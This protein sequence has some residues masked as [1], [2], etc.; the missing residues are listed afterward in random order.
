MMA[1]IAGGASSMALLALLLS[2][3]LASFPW[4]GDVPDNL[5]TPMIASVVEAAEQLPNGHWVYR[6]RD[7]QT[8]EIDY[9]ET[10]S[11]GGGPG[12]GRLLLA[13]TDPDG[14]RWVHGLPLAPTIGRPA[15]C[16]EMGGYG[17][18]V[19]GWIETAGGWRL[20]KAADFLDRRGDSDDLFDSERG[21]FCLNERGEVFYYDVL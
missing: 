13:G 15:G 14:R 16:F 4:S 6:L 19:D 17:R 10:T 9:D 5:R 7:G 1:R 2:G 12:V 21:V 11:L 8:L 18:A 20:R 3:C